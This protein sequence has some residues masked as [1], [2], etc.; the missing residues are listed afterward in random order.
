VALLSCGGKCLKAAKSLLVA[1]SAVLMFSPMFALAYC[2]GW[3]KQLPNYDPQYYSVSHEFARTKLVITGKVTG[4]KWLGEDGKEKPLQPPFQSNGQRPS[5]FDPYVGVEYAIEVQK[6][7]KGP[8]SKRL[9]LFSENSSGRYLMETGKTYVLFVSTQDFGEEIGVR[10][11]VDNC[12]N[13]RPLEKA[14]DVL[15]Q[16]QQHSGR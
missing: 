1:G 14:E 3:D 16:L 7:F 10:L 13:S 8:P 5:G 12:G 15:K 6:V 2:A 4:E 11:N 9:A